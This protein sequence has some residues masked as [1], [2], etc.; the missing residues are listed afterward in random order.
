MSLGDLLIEKLEEQADK[1]VEKIP[2]LVTKL[3]DQ[4]EGQ[5]PEVDESDDTL[6]ALVRGGREGLAVLRAREVELGQLGQYGLTAFL[7]HLA[8]GDVDQATRLYLRQQAGWDE[9]FQASEASSRDLELKKR[10]HD[11]AIKFVKEIGA[12]VARAVLPFILRALPLP[13]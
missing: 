8:A 5:I 1:A 4:A 9:L 10:R 13:F 6:Y 2:G 7:A 12:D 11:A 3:L